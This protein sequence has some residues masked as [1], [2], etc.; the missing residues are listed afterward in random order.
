[1]SSVFADPNFFTTYLKKSV[2]SATKTKLL[3]IFDLYHD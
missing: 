1:M 2:E 3:I